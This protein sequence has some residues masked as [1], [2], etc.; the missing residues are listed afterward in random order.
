MGSFKF[1]EK[2]GGRSPKKIDALLDQKL[3]E[4]EW[5]KYRIGDLFKIE[6]TA[7]FNSDKLVEGN[8]YD[9]VTRTSFNQGILKSTGFVNEE[10]LNPSRNWS[11]GLLQMDFFYRKKEWYAGQFVRKITPRFEIDSHV[12][13]FFTTILN[14]LKP[15]LLSVLVRNVDD[16]FSNAI[17]DLPT[18]NGQIDFNFI[19]DFVAELEAQ[20]VAELEAYLSVTGLK[21]YELTQE[22]KEEVDNIAR[23]EWKEFD[24]TEIFNIKNTKSILSREIIPNSGTVPY[25]CASAENNSVSSNIS[26]REELK[27]RGNCIFIGGKTFVVSYQVSDFFSNDSHNLALYMKNEELADRAHQLYL[28]TCIRKSLA[29]KY[30]WGDSISNTK[31]KKDK[32]TLPVNDGGA[33]DFNRMPSLISAVQKLVIKNVVLYAD[34]KIEASNQVLGLY[35]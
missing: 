21:D 18:K 34:E 24:V 22:E 33:V 14:S 25:L 16:T 8:A 32:I 10:N 27:D 20:R 2:R 5:G 19:E 35:R 17:V 4:V 3:H 11:L 13:P 1:N 6:K 28:A 15:V 12:E 31:I 26:Y 30:S 7:S 29:H 9:Y 23:I